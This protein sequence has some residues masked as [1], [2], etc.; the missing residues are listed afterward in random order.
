MADAGYM[1]SDVDAAIER[2]R[3]ECPKAKIHRWNYGF[4]LGV[5]SMDGSHLMLVFDAGPGIPS[6]RGDLDAIIAGLK[7]SHLSLVPNE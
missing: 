6:Y 7:K 1:L 3:R 2:I 5:E 4:T